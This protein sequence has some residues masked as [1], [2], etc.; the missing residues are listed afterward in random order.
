MDIVL[1][2]SVIH[3]SSHPFDYSVVRS[4][5]SHEQRFQHT[6]H[7]IQT[8]RQK[9]PKA[10]IVLIEGSEQRLSEEQRQ[11]L[12]ID[13]LH[14]VS[15]PEIHGT[16]K[17]RGECRLLYDYLNSDAFKQMEAKRIFKISGRYY[18]TDE[19]SLEN[20]DPDLICVRKYPHYHNTI[21]YSVPSKYVDWYKE[22]LRIILEEP[23]R[24]YE[25]VLFETLDHQDREMAK[26][27]PV[28][29]VTG[30]GAVNNI[31]GYE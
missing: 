15:H 16:N 28:L 21:L 30:I 3:I 23:F 29:G 19:F 20:Y 25:N 18:L 22:R 11:Q 14:E 6:I 8:I 10:Y 2:T 27:L 31:Q 9:M 1:I 26:Y 24:G 4:I 12:D 13:Y 7:T 17:S 5:F